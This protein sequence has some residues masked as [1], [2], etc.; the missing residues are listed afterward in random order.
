MDNTPRGRKGDLARKERPNNPDMLWVDAIAQQGLSA[1][2]ISKLYKHLGDNKNQ[3]LWRAKYD[4]IKQKI[5]KLYWNEEDGIYYDINKNTLDH[6]KVVTPASYWPMLAEMCDSIQAR[7]MTE[8]ISN[9]NVLGGEV[10]WTSVARNDND[11]DPEGGY[12]RGSIW[13]PTAYMG[14]KALEK[15]GYYDLARNNALS[16]IDH[17]SKTYQFYKPNT[18]WECYNPTKPKPAQTVHGDVV[19]P[20]FCGWSA[21]G[22]ISMMI[23]NVIGFYDI[24]AESKIVK[25]NLDKKGRQGIK[26]LIFGNIKTN[27]VYERGHVSVLS[28]KKYTLLINDKSYT[29][30]KGENLIVL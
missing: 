10:P 25:W 12:W 3:E 7:R 16:I 22:P 6:I 24:D 2:S 15:Y 29:I 30:K 18:I 8:H 21:L 27:I 4:S 20:D 19:R 28:N 23:E 1:L 26:N 9:P 11:F 5:N 17:M 14:I 13:L